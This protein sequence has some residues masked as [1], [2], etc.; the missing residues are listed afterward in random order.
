MPSRQIRVAHI[1]ENAKALVLR[2]FDRTVPVPQDAVAQGLALHCPCLTEHPRRC[3]PH[4]SG[5]RRHFERSAPLVGIQPA[6]GRRV[7]E[8][9]PVR[10]AEVG[11]ALARTRGARSCSSVRPATN[12]CSTPCAPRGQLMCR[13][14]E[15]PVGCR[16]H[17]PRGGTRA[18]VVVHYRR[19]R[20]DAPGG[21]HGYA[22]ARDFRTVTA[23]AVRTAVAAVQNRAHRHSL[24]SVQ[25]D[26]A[27]AR[28][29][30]LTV[31]PIASPAS[32]LPTCS[33]RRTRCS[34]RHEI[35]IDRGSSPLRPHWRSS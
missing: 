18:P 12:P 13:S 28:H 34:T 16:S 10:F 23:H 8:W 2:A 32:R 11:A 5:A 31:C 25:L 9:D 19:Y 24:Q 21:G 1:A 14:I 17:R 27:A 35:A 26:A 20:T 15:L 4:S 6:T 33:A 29:A 22:G 7:K 3:A 30:A